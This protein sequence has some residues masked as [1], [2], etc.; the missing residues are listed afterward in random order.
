MLFVISFAD[1][2]P[3]ETNIPVL[4]LF[5]LKVFTWTTYLPH[6]PQIYLS[7]YHIPLLK[8]YTWRSVPVESAV[9]LNIN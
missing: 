7:E 8:K 9:L 5:E 2:K 6:F 4:I 1:S 3:E